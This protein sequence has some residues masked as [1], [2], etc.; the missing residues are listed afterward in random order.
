MD[1]SKI[2]NLLATQLPRT[3]GIKLAQLQLPL[4]LVSKLASEATVVQKNALNI[5]YRRGRK[6]ATSSLAF[7]AVIY[8]KR[9]IF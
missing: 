2:L 7:S 1:Q 3:S 5:M 8:R 9:S 4:R 6:M